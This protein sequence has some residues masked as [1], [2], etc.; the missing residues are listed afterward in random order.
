MKDHKTTISFEYDGKEYTLEYT[1]SALKQMERQGFKFAKLDEIVLTAPLE[2]FIGAFNAN[3]KNT[4]RKL[5]EEIYEQLC[6]T[7]E[8]GEALTE[9]IGSMLSEAIEELN[10]HRGNIKWSKNS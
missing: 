3:H 9:V 10:S 1:A 4:P 2:L 7:E 6:E 5:R 8:G